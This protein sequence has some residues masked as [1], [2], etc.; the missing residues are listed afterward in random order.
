MILVVK[1]SISL[2]QKRILYNGWWWCKKQHHHQH[3]HLKLNEY[4]S[5]SPSGHLPIY[6]GL[7]LIYG[8]YS[9]ITFVIICTPTYLDIKCWWKIRMLIFGLNLRNI[10]ESFTDTQT[11][12]HIF[13]LWL[14]LPIHD[15]LAAIHMARLNGLQRFPSRASYMLVG[16]IS[17]WWRLF[18][19]GYDLPVYDS[20]LPFPNGYFSCV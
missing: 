19:E 1:G 11:S 7:C 10:V 3:D 4:S 16:V 6:W 5:S 17:T 13:S 9:P 15:S 8:P 14:K 2:I 18:S 20:S 12:W